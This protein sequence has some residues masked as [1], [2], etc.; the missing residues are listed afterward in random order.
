MIEKEN[1]MKMINKLVRRYIRMKG[2][3]FQFEVKKNKS[4]FPEVA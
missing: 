2:Y 4:Y 3:H 1:D